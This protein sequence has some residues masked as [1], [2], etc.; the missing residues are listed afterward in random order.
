[1]RDFVEVSLDDMEDNTIENFELVMNFPKKR[2]SRDD[3]HSLTIK[4][5]G[6]V[7]QAVLFVQD[8]DS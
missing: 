1:M 6:L 3:D 8:L 4:E 5:A 7:P 2:F